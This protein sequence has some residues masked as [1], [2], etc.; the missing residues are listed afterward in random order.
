MLDPLFNGVHSQKLYKIK[1]KKTCPIGQVS[2]FKQYFIS[3]FARI[4][5]Y[6]CIVVQ[7]LKVS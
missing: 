3:E 6:W 1:K 7:D 2:L 5:Q 4:I